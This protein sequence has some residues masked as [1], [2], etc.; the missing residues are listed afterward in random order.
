MKGFKNV[1]G[2]S[3][4]KKDGNHCFIINN[5]HEYTATIKIRISLQVRLNKKLRMRW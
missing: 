2:R 1:L 3:A 5:F 4:L